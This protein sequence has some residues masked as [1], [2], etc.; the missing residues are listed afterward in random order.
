MSAPKRKKTLISDSESGGSASEG[1]DLDKE[2]LNISKRKKT[3]ESKAESGKS[4]SGSET[5]SGSDDEWTGKSGKKKVKKKTKKR[6]SPP[7]KKAEASSS[8]DEGENSEG[9]NNSEPEEGEVNESGSGNESDSDAGSDKSEEFNDGYDENL[10]GDDEDRRRLEQMTEKEREQELFNRIEQREVLKTRFEIE[11]KLKKA[12]EKEQRMKAKKEG[13]KEKS[14][15]SSSSPVRAAAAEPSNQRLKEV[16]AKRGTSTKMQ[17]LNELRLQREKKK[18]DQEDREK[19]RRDEEEK[20]QEAKSKKKKNKLQANEVFS[21]SDESGKGSDKSDDEDAGS[22]KGSASP[23]RRS[24]SRSSSSSS[25]SSNSS[26]SGSKSRSRSRSS[27]SGSD[28]EVS[29]ENSKP[30]TITTKEEL[31]RIRISRFKLERWVHT[32][33]FKDTVLNCFARVNIGTNKGEAVYRITEI[34]GVKETGKIYDFGA[35]KTNKAL[36]LR[37]A[38]AERDYRLEY[39]SNSDFT[40][41]EY[42]KWIEAMTTADLPLPTLKEVEKK[43]RSIKEAYAFKFNDDSISKMVEEK[44]KFR[45]NPINYAMRKTRLQK[46]L[47]VAQTNGEVEKAEGLKTQ[48]DALEERAAELDRQRT[49][50]ISSVTYINER[51]R[52]NNIRVVSNAMVEEFQIQKEQAAD[53]FMRK[54]SA[55][56]MVNMA[57]DETGKVKNSHH[58]QFLEERYSSD[59][60]K[61][62]RDREAAKATALTAAA[63]AKALL[64]GPLKDLEGPRV[65]STGGGGSRNEDL[66]SCHDFDVNIDLNVPSSLPTTT[67]SNEPRLGTN[68]TPGG[69]SGP[70]RT[71]NLEDYKRKKGL[72]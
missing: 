30:K 55:P 19:Q 68:L 10:M 45:K 13:K 8:E 14:S 22:A 61:W 11:R 59:K 54:N 4:S 49:K 1:E 9:G 66:F 41:K 69:S 16:E 42:E 3:N 64:E 27:G 24:R 46:V 35:S 23:K 33:F 6:S 52:T 20:K 70:K 2:L 60:P 53:P 26:K 18:Q 17:K 62:V 25:S 65:N 71:L 51:N 48:L 34:V 32:P 44:E 58:M 56:I 29:R 37:Y 36:R 38:K 43:E 21:S 31:N 47:E 28:N 50:N 67:P 5:S 72:I 63:D 40:D 7:P 12:K 39:I 15:S 57:K